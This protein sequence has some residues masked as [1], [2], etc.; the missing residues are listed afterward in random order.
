M[1]NQ[2]P[3]PGTL[4]RHFK[5]NLYQIVTI[6]TDSENLS[7][8]VVYQALYGDYK[9]YVRPLDMFL[10]PTD[11]EKYPDATQ[12]YRFEK[13]D[14]ESLSLK[15][16]DVPDGVNPE[17][18]HFLYATDYHDKLFIFRGLQ[19]SCDIKFLESIA[20]VLDIAL[21]GKSVEEDYYFILRYLETEVKFERRNR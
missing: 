6:A 18:I 1:N 7:E 14:R 19:N 20:S 16:Q 17:L 10:S 3:T 5:G 2:R 13:V 4:Y 11:K 8:M 15:E 9:T 21:E 12:E